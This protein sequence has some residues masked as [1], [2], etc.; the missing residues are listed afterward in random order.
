[1]FP[2]GNKINKG[3]HPSIKTRKKLSMSRTGEKNHM[4]GKKH[5]PEVI[6]KMR[7]KKLGKIMPPGTGE[8][9]RKAHTGKKHSLEWKENIKNSHIGVPRPYLTGENNPAWKG[10]TTSLGLKVRGSMQN[11]AWKRKV[12]ERDNWTCQKCI[13][14]GGNL[15]V[16]HIKSFSDIIEEEKIKSFGDIRPESQL[17]DINN[18]Q[19]LCIK[20]HKETGKWGRK[21]KIT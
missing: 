1:M 3:R 13:Q 7:L 15:E 4:Y 2:I 17:W 8:K 12:F 11:E 6:E 9:I 10:G 5:P 20:H 16:H 21:R 14:R 19:T 18:G